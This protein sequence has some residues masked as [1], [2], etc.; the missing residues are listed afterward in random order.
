MPGD[1]GVFPHGP[2]TDFDL[3]GES[4]VPG[5]AV[6]V[7]RDGKR[8]FVEAGR[9]SD[10]PDAAVVS[11][12]TIY[13][14]ASLTKLLC[15]VACAMRLVD[16]GALDLET[17]IAAHLED[18]RDG[19]KATITVADLLSHCSGLPA[20]TELFRDGLTGADLQRAILRTELATPPRAQVAYSDVGMIVL[21]EVLERMTGRRLDQLFDEQVRFPLGL[22]ETTFCPSDALR[23]RIAPTEDDPWRGHLAHGQVHDENAFA[24]G[25]IAP[26]AGLFSTVEDLL[27]F[28][29]ALLPPELAGS[30][31]VSESTFEQFLAPSRISASNWA[32]GL[33]RLGTDSTYPARFATS[34]VG[35]T[36]FT[37]TVLAMDRERRRV[38]VILSNAVYPVRER[39]FRSIEARARLAEVALA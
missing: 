19:L 9:L 39:R 28:G 1:D 10:A 15:P 8:H 18:F 25:G 35:V 24:L 6:G 16:A 30:G 32:H 37:G 14:I 17:P 2:V 3:V 33:R 22:H 26:H 4:G 38:V 34:V 20:V 36:G 12:T 29:N 5:L 27:A 7:L 23:S 11:R 21:G 31:F 13:D